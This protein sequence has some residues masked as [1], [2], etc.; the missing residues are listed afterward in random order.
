MLQQYF[1][2]F[3]C[4]CALSTVKKN[5]IGR[6]NLFNIS[7]VIEPGGRRRTPGAQEKVIMQQAVAQFTSR[8]IP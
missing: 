4:V 8:K 1:I 5:H 3:L 6:V 7:T 2:L